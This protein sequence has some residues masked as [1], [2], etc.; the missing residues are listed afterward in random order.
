MQK[1]LIRVVFQNRTI[2]LQKC[3]K[4]SLKT[5]V[6]G[7]ET[8]EEECQMVTSQLSLGIGHWANFGITLN[9]EL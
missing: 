1:W 9:C 3:L 2:N 8:G 7:S 5:K 6:A 4:E